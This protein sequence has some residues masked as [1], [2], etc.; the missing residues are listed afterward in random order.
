M[1]ST[2]EDVLMQKLRGTRWVVC[3]EPRARLV[4]KGGVDNS[5]H[6]PAFLHRKRV[7]GEMYYL[8]R[9]MKLPAWQRGLVKLLRV[10]EYLYFDLT[11]SPDYLASLPEFSR[12]YIW[13]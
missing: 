11:E 12:E 10:G 2:G 1:S 7:C 4:H 3:M 13:G 8:R 5:K 9:Y 6:P